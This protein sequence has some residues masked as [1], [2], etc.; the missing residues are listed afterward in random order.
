M[1]PEERINKADEEAI[2][3]QEMFPEYELETIRQVLIDNALNIQNSV[4]SLMNMY[5]DNE[6]DF[7]DSESQFD[8]EINNQILEQ[9]VE[10]YR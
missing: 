2:F 10:A 4:S 7:D 5:Q 3:I 9:I 6:T 8:E 1:T